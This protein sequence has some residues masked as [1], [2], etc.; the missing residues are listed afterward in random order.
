VEPPRQLPIR[1]EPPPPDHWLV[2]RGGIDSPASLR[3]KLNRSLDLF[4]SALISVV[5]VNPLDLDN[6]LKSRVMIGYNVIT[7]AEVQTLIAARFRLL[8][9]FRAP[10]YSVEFGDTSDFGIQRFIDNFSKRV[11]NPFHES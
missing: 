10:H 7:I 6:A 4:G 5:V 11:E 8:P 3:S 1:A 2:L 9:T